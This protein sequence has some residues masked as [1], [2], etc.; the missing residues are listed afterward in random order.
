MT[1]DEAIA[2][3]IRGHIAEVESALKNAAAYYE[4]PLS[5]RNSCEAARLRDI[6]ESIRKSGT[7]DASISDSAAV[8]GHAM[9]C[10]RMA[11]KLLRKGDWRGALLF[12]STGSRGY[13]VA[14]GLMGGQSAKRELLQSWA[15]LRH[16]ETYEMR[17]RIIDHWK[18]KISPTL[19]A[20]KAADEMLGLF[21]W[22][23]GDEVAHRKLAEYVGFAKRELR[24][25]GR[26]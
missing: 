9:Y 16:A 22:S 25:A 18:K 10:C 15:K 19:S 4:F 1:G 3:E 8:I 24:S 17:D 6:E 21:R 2:R 14:L 20:Q 23:N 5:G 26:V 12:T 11:K 7:S 13:G